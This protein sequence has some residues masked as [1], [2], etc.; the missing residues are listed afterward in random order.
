MRRGGSRRISPNCRSYCAKTKALRPPPLAPTSRPYPRTD[1][2]RRRTTT[3]YGYNCPSDALTIPR[4]QYP[5][6]TARTDFRLPYSP[7]AFLHF[8]SFWLAEWYRSIPPKNPLRNGSLN[9]QKIFGIWACD[10]GHSAPLIR[11]SYVAA[12][13]QI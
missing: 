7:D 5:S 10:V 13:G 9:F 4:Q 8:H 6:R 3:R 1:T 12:L 2:R 11:P